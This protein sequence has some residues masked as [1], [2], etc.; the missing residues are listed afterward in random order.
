MSQ[1]IENNIGKYLFIKKLKDLAFVQK[2]ILFGSRARGANQ[3]RSD[4]D[5]ALI[6]PGI[7]TQQWHQV[8]EV[9]ENAD[10]LLEIDCL[11]FEKADDDLKQRILKDG[12]EL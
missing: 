4:I 12:V 9:V 5:L 7:T 3:A 8:L 6:C 1:D 10:T 2:V 11:Q